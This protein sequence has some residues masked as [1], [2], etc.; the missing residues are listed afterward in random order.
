[1]T[2]EIMCRWS[3][4]THIPVALLLLLLLLLFVGSGWP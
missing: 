4:K 2:V 1:M 3:S